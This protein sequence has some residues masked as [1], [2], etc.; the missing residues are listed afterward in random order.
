MTIKK[1]MKNHGVEFY[2]EIDGHKVYFVDCMNTGGEF[3]TEMWR[4]GKEQQN[5]CPCCK[6]IIR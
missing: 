2:E 5:K 1:T 6:E 4:K 3:S